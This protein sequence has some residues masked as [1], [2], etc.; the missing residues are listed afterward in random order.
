VAREREGQIAGL[1]QALNE[2]NEKIASLDRAVT[3]REG[4]ILTLNQALSE[5][6]QKIA[7]LDKAVTERDGWVA[8]LNRA[9]S[10]REQSIGALND[11]VKERDDQIAVLGR[12]LKQILGSRSWRYTKILRLFGRISRGEWPA[13]LASLKRFAGITTAT[14]QSLPSVVSQGE[15]E[16]KQTSVKDPAQKAIA[17]NSHLNSD[18][19]KSAK[20]SSLG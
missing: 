7:A 14:T 16:A 11:A 9:L 1:N 12:R 6:R 19:P 13:V 4:Q 3:E 18:Q 8:D 2:A 17:S 15:Q 5:G 10:E 20:E